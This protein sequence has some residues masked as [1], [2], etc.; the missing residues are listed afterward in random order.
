M[1]LSF[2]TPSRT[3]LLISDEALFVY[4]INSR[5]VKLIESV[6]WD[7]DGFEDYVAQLIAKDCSGKPILILNDMVEQ[8]YRKEKVPKVGP[9]DKQNVLQRKLKVSFPNYTVRAALPLKEK[10]PKSAGKTA[11]SLYIFAAIPATDQF[12]KTMS[13]ATKSMASIA[14]V[15]LLPVE[16]ADMIKK[17]SLKLTD[18]AEEKSEWT[19]FI[20]QHESGG[21]RQ[22]VVKN[23]E[24]ALTRMTPII[25]KDED[26]VLWAKEVHQEFQATMSYLSRFG[27]DSNQG[28]DVILVSSE[29][30]G[31]IV[32]E[33]IDTPCRFHAMESEEIARILNTPYGFQEVSSHF[34]HV[35][36]VGWIGKKSKFILPMKAKQID[37][38]SKPRQVISVLSIL[39]VLAACF[40]AYQILSHYQVITET[41]DNVETVTQRKARLDIQLQKEVDRK[42][43]LGFDIQLIQSS[44]LVHGDLEDK[45]INGL[46]LFQNV[47]RALGR[48]LRIDN[49]NLVRGRSVTLSNRVFGNAKP[50]LYTA[51]LQMTFPSTTDA[52]KGNKEVMDFQKRLQKTLPDHIVKVTKLLE[53]YEYNEELIVETGDKKGKVVNQDYIAEISIEGPEKK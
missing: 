1:S 18:K 17:L 11:A 8:H 46:S 36:H 24:L 51:S 44:L 53:D 50:R 29:A 6:L 47:G 14:G 32:E 22:V 43:E 5:G 45:K 40:L 4:T 35:I 25:D 52:E 28:L 30:E 27:F 38:V 7:V 12:N 15:C 21:L 48:D 2:L 49:F 23:G 26:P 9:L 3:I 19:I 39:L 13:A 42:K 41:Q 31:N 33:L 16:S 10:I 20:G 34:A 37:N